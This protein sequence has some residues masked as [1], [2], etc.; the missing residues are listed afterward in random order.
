M[1]PHDD[2]GGRN[3]CI[4]HYVERPGEKKKHREIPLAFVYDL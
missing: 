1:T 3:I 2:D 4:I